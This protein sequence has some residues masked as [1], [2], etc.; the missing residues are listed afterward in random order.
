MWPLEK[1]WQI[2]FLWCVTLGAHQ[3]NDKSEALMLV[4]CHLSQR[5][6]PLQK[7]TTGHRIGD[8]SEWL[9]WLLKCEKTAPEFDFKGSINCFLFPQIHSKTIDTGRN[10]QWEHWIFYFPDPKVV[11]TFRVLQRL[12]GQDLEKFHE[13]SGLYPEIS[14]NWVWKKNMVYS[15]SH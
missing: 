15:M 8:D 1:G 6:E 12:E 2:D 14:F 7:V 5:Q 13:F 3:C 4:L 10:W 11:L 9:E